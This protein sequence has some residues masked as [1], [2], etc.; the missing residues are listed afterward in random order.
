MTTF[1][2]VQGCWAEPNPSA[3]LLC[4]GLPCAETLAQLRCYL[5]SYP[6]FI[7]RAP[8]SPRLGT[9]TPPSWNFLRLDAAHIPRSSAPGARRIPQKLT[10]PSCASQ[11]E[12]SFNLNSGDRY[13]NSFTVIPLLDLVHGL[14]AWARHIAQ[15]H[16]RGTSPWRRKMHP[17]TCTI[18]V[19]MLAS[20]STR[21][22]Q[23]VIEIV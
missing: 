16:G 20:L 11:A 19:G 2:S 22:Y 13:P 12:N 1:L 17:S 21:C 6:C 7:S 18:A 9:F 3:P 5:L 15:M 23:N 8:T 4:S 10:E 14:E